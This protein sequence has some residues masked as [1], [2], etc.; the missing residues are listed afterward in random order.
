MAFSTRRG[1]PRQQHLEAPDRGTAELRRHRQ[2]QHTAE[3]I[4]RLLEEEFISPDQHRSAMHFRWLYT[5][6]F[7]TPTPAALDP[8]RVRGR[9]LKRSYSEWQE[10]R[11]EEWREAVALLQ[12]QQAYATILAISIHHQPPRSHQEIFRLQQ[13][14]QLLADSW[15]GSSRRR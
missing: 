3:P 5:L 13:G 11:E 6:R 7:G 1:R 9:I 12:Q 15:Y 2:F 4:D 8:A 14:L 10:A